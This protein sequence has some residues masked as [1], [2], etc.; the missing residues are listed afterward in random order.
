MESKRLSQQRLSSNRGTGS[1]MH[2]RKTQLLLFIGLCFSILQLNQVTAQDPERVTGLVVAEGWQDVQANCTECHSA[3][4]ITQNSGSRAVW[5]SRIR[6]MQE[7]Q[8]LQDLTAELETSILDY[9]AEHYGQKDA[10]RRT[11][12]GQHLLP[13]NPYETSN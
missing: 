8:G 6:W 9:L 12:L 4:L 3:L 10:T 13:A 7:T 1:L 5:E 11:P 2:L